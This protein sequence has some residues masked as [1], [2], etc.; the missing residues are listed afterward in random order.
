MKG[1]TPDMG[2][3]RALHEVISRATSDSVHDYIPDRTALRRLSAF[4]DHR[5]PK[6]G[7]V[8]AGY[9]Y[10]RLESPEVSFWVDSFYFHL[11]CLYVP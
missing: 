3:G 8:H 6:G 4:R 7:W 2:L 5:V 10:R 1:N 9:G 11:P